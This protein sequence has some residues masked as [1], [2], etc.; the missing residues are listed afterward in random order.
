MSKIT[1]IKAIE[2]AEHPILLES[3]TQLEQVEKIW[4]QREILGIDTE[5]VRERTYR[6]ALGLIQISDGETA[7]LLDPLAINS[8]GP[9]LRMMED[10]GILKLL[11]SG[12]EDLEVLLQSVGTIPEPLVDTQIACAMMG[13]SLQ[14]GYHH[15]LKWLFDVDIDKDQTRSNWCKRPLNDNQLRYAAMDVVL[16][17]EMLVTLRSRLEDAGRW[18]W[19][20]EDVARMKRNAL[21]TTDP[22]YAYLRFSAIGRMGNGT[23]QVMKYLARWREQVAIERNRARGFVISDSAMLQLARSKPSTAQELRAIE[24]IHPVALSRYEKTLLQLIVDAANDP[25]P[26][27]KFEQLDNRQM[28][29]LKNMR[30]IVQSRSAELGVD[31]ALLASR[32]E[33]EKLIRA[34]AADTPVPERF[35]GWRK[36]VV[37]DQLLEQTLQ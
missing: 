25:T 20:E 22:E 3:L 33:L 32:K 7:W 19:L 14:L 23:L 11:H 2:A 10:P 9:L 29:Q 34:L 13:Q 17:P 18:S 30:R 35:L 24:D 26:V 28:L 4:A 8:Y 37:T 1:I 5:F 6:A 16:L 31:P 12:T 15:A 27:E 21:E 36:E